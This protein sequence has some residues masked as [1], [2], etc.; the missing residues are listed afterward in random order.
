MQRQF[1]INYLTRLSLI[2]MMPAHN[3]FDALNAVLSVETYDM[4]GE[5][6]YTLANSAPTSGAPNAQIEQSGL[7]ADLSTLLY[8]DDIRYINDEIF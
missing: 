4:I 7:Q 3:M 1:S 5:R 2:L 8:K 6:T